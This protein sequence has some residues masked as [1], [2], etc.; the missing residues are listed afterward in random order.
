MIFS[1]ASAQVS[2]SIMSVSLKLNNVAF[3]SR[4]IKGFRE[5]QADIYDR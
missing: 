4:K 2:M 5:N 3:Q 1:T